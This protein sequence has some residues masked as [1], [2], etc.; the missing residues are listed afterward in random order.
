MHSRCRAKLGLVM[1][2]WALSPMVPAW[3]QDIGEQGAEMPP[4]PPRAQGFELQ[5]GQRRPNRFGGDEPMQRRFRQGGQG[6]Q[7]RGGGMGGGFGGPIDLRPLNLT[8]EQKQKIQTMRRQTAQN[9][10]QVRM[11]LKEKR[12][13]LKE[14]M[15]DP[16]ATDSQIREKRLEV[17]TAQDKMDELLVNDFLKMRAVLT[18][19]QL[20]HLPEAK[21]QPKGQDDFSEH[22]PGR[23]HAPME[24]GQPGKEMPSEI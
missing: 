2:M 6:R 9:M 8:E 1:F 21:P 20:G 11:G 24:R 10:R 17:R 5:P 15:F 22:G 7:M 13:Q 16:K 12:M 14:M 18:K 4:P 19:E 23:N 3:A